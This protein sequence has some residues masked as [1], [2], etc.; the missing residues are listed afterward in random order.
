MGEPSEN[1]NPLRAILAK[2]ALL[3]TIPTQPKRKYYHGKVT[4][5]YKEWRKV[6]R[7]I[8]LQADGV[9]HRIMMGF[10]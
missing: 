8:E 7:I 2:S 5:A 6:K 9:Y 3:E 4:K 10:E 1:R